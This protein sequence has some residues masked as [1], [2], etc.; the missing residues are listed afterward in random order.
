MARESFRLARTP[1][2][3][4]ER[5]DAIAST[6]SA[7]KKRSV[8]GAQRF[9]G[10]TLSPRLGRLLQEAHQRSAVVGADDDLVRHLGAGG[11]MR[12]ADLEKFRDRLSVP[13]DLELFQ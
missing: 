5:A 2:K 8:A 9:S 7:C 12:R 11:V 13:H 10:S 1:L 6:I 3:L 4:S